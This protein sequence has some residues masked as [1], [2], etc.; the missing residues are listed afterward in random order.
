MIITVIVVLFVADKL[1]KVMSVAGAVFGMIN[2]LL[3]PA[4]CHLK[5]TA[6]TRCQKIQDILIMIF[7]CA[8]L[9]FGPFTIILQ[10]GNSSE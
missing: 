8:M 10:W 2:V 9:V 1:D 3:L 6:E 7:A 4:I 5:L